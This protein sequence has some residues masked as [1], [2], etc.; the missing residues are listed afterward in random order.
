MILWF[1]TI[2]FF[3]KGV[4]LLFEELNIQSPVFSMG[5]DRWIVQKVINVL[6]ELEETLESGLIP[7]QE[8]WT[9]LQ[10]LPAPWGP[11][12]YESIRDLRSRGA[13]LLPTLR[14]LRSLA[15]SHSEALND[16]KVKSA[17]ALGQAIA[18]GFLVPLFGGVLFVLLPGLSER[19]YFWSA[20]CFLA[21]VLSG[22][23]AAWVLSMA[24]NARWGGLKTSQRPWTLSAQCAGERFLALVRSGQPP[25]LAWT[26]TCKIMSVDS[27]ELALAW[28]YSVFES[29]LTPAIPWNQP[30]LAKTLI[31][32]GTSIRKSIHVSLMEG[33]PS[34]ERVESALI[35]LRQEIKSLVDRELALL[36]NRALKPLFLCVAPSLL[37]LLAIGM[38]VTWTSLGE[39]L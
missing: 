15:Q 7:D 33:R 39:N 30:S 19:P 34:I 36:G 12:A 18:C 35:A 25:D 2:L 31:Q 4:K 6:L 16:A 17:Q 38:W 24:Q 28:G 23:G 21:L 29:P 37:G 1:F 13:P 9:T 11:L 14:R 5:K 3:F 20:A 22:S 10:S 8:K 32:T 26:E 27:P